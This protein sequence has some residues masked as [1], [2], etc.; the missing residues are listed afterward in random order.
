MALSVRHL[1][2]ALV[3]TALAGCPRSSPPVD[4]APEP[5]LVELQ[6]VEHSTP[7]P[8]VTTAAQLE[9][10]A[11]EPAGDET[12]EP[13]E[14]PTE[15]REERAEAQEDP[16]AVQEETAEVQEDPTAVEVE[17]GPTPSP[18]AVA[19]YRAPGV[20]VESHLA[21]LEVLRDSSEVRFGPQ[22]VTPEQIREG[23][24][25]E[26]HVVLFTGGR[27]SV[28]GREL[29]EEG[30]QIVRDFVRGGGGY[31]GVCAGS[32]LAMQGSEEFYKLAIVA[33]QNLSGDAWRR[34]VHTVEVREVGGEAVHRMFYANGPVFEPIEVAGLPPIQPLA[35]YLSDAYLPAHGTS[36]GEMPG[37]PGILATSYGRGRIVLFSPNPVLSAEEEEPEPELMIEAVRWVA[38]PGPV[39]RPIEF[40]D[41]FR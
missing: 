4:P 40:N 13:R 24:L 27:G 25:E 32:Y 1:L 36:S 15:L 8:P 33:A 16:T 7:A 17:A 29:G 22:I 9:P 10:A 35:I 19:L 11:E 5:E 34:G 38:T 23:A 2:F 3:I 18:V 37:T 6:A 14:E 26:F 28:Q 39:P 41:V 12:V 30:R 20:S 31:I 21:T